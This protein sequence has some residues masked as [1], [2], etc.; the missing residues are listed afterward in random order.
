M[1]NIIDFWD[2]LLD[3]IEEEG[4][5][6]SP[7]G[8]NTWVRTIKPYKIINNKLILSVPMDVNKEMIEKRYLTLIKSAAIILNP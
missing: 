1:N 8:F 6:I 4:R 2:N 5:Q 7:L 3:M